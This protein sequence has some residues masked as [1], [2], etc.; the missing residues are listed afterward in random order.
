MANMSYC[1]FENTLSDLGDCLGAMEEAES[2]KDLD[3]N[4]YE[5]RAFME[6]F[7]TCR[8]FLAEHERLLNAEASQEDE[9]EV[10]LSDKCFV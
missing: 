8:A 3:L 7:R 6:M 4:E 5:E 1:R 10:D 2:L 9:D